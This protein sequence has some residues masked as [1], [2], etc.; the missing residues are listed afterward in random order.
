MY[1]GYDIES[2]K[3]A[4]TFK[5]LNLES[6]NALTN[7]MLITQVTYYLNY[8]DLVLSDVTQY[9]ARSLNN[10]RNTVDDITYPQEGPTTYS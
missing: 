2:I 1:S 5:V 9:L 4:Q 10:L 3:S 8:V 7:N 6:N